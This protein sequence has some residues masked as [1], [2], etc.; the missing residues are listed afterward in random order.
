MLITQHHNVIVEYDSQELNQ[1]QLKASE[2]SHLY[3]PRQQ[4]QQ[5]VDG[6]IRG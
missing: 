4:R 1:N 6:Q 2:L 3:E 5:A